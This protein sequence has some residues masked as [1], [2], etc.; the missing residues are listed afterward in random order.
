MQR[1]T[2]EKM[3]AQR[4]RVRQLG[5]QG[6]MVLLHGSELNID[7]EGNVDWGPEFLEGFDVLVASVHTEVNQ[8]KE[9]MTRRIVQ[10]C[11]NPFVNMSGHPTGRKI[12]QR[13]ASEVDR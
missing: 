7:A 9:E 5:K 4:K 13:A 12:G 2:D 10:A 1:M 6:K 3:L 8:P 11:E